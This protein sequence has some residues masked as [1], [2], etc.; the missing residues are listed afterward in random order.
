MTLDTKIEQLTIADNTT[1]YAILKE[2]LQISQSSNS[3]YPYMDTFIDMMQHQKNSY[4]RTRGLQLISANAKWDKDNKINGCINEYL[5]HIE[6]DKPITSRLCI[7]ETV[8]IAKYKPE[9]IEII[10]N[11]LQTC[12]TIYQDSMQSL[13]YK[14]RKQAIQ[15]IKSYISFDG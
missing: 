7:K 2:L 4:I 1:A 5:K 3:L 14:D 11:A 12:T 15:K 8:R 10:L 9:L 6:D 13:I